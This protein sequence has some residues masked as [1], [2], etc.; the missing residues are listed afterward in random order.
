ME[1]CINQAKNMI[2]SG[3]I[4]TQI[5]L[6][7]MIARAIAEETDNKVDN[8]IVSYINTFCKAFGLKFADLLEP[9]D[10]QKDGES[11]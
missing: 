5:V 4:L 1:E 3:D 9:K 8:R 6:F 7:V 10:D 11:Q 2:M